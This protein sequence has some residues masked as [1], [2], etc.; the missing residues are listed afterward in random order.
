VN[1]S[2][3]YAS[4]KGSRIN[5]AGEL[6]IDDFEPGDYEMLWNLIME[7][8]VIPYLRDRD[9]YH[10]LGV[11]AVRYGKKRMGARFYPETYDPLTRERPENLN[12]QQQLAIIKHFIT[13]RKYSYY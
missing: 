10:W 12:V 9:Y 5:I 3:F 2:E 13:K 11:W 6:V 7:T 1:L 4:L 8:I